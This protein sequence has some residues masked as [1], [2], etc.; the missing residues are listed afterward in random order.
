MLLLTATAM[1][2]VQKDMAEKL[3]EALESGDKE[4]AENARNTMWQ[5]IYQV[6]KS[7]YAQGESWND[8]A[9]RAVPNE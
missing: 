9:P 3:K 6:Y 2:R 1:R 5:G 7:I 8:L 4:A